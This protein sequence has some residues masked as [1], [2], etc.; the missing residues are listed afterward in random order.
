MVSDKDGVQAPGRHA[1]ASHTILDR[2]LLVRH[3]WPA[4]STVKSAKNIL[5][6][7]GT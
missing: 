3:K 1:P 5:S 7:D 6:V 2:A 4:T